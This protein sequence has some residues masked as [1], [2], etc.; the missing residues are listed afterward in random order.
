MLVPFIIFVVIAGFLI[1]NVALGIFGVLWYTI[2][3]RRGEIGLRRA[4]GATG[5]AISWQLVVEAVLIATLALVIGSL[6]AIQFPLLNLLDLPSENYI[7][8]IIY[9]IL[10]IYVLVILCAVY[11]GKQASGIY[12]ATALHE[13]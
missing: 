12:P 7:T 1:I 4:V 2:H 11:P 8:A 13:D 9:A 3:K 6:F 10:F 5:R